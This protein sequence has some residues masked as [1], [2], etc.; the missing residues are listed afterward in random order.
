MDDTCVCLRTAHCIETSF[1]PA[2]SCRT[3]DRYGFTRRRTR[4]QCLCEEGRN[5]L[6]GG[7]GRDRAH[8]GNKNFNPL[9][10][11][12]VFELSINAC[13]LYI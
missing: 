4:P 5:G 1:T 10:A 11:E 12:P 2:N 7:G 9:I 13:Q 3:S 8:Y 6:G